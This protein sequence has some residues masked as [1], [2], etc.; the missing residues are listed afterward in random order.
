M[1]EATIGAHTTTD[2]VE[3]NFGCYDY[4][5]RRWVG[6]SPEN[7]SGIAQQMRMHDLERPSQVVSDCRKAKQAQPARSMGFFYELPDSMQRSLV[8]ACRRFRLK[9]RREARAD[10]KAQLAYKQ[11]KQEENI[12]LYAKSLR[13]FPAWQTNGFTEIGQ[14]DKLIKDKAV[15]DA[16]K[17]KQL[18]SQIEMR[19][20]ALGMSD[21]ATSFSCATDPHVGSIPHLR[22]V[23][24]EV[25]VEAKARRRNGAPPFQPDGSAPTEAQPPQLQVKTLEVL[26]T[27]TCDCKRLAAE[28]RLGA[29]TL[30]DAAMA[31]RQH[32]IEAGID[33]SV[34]E[35]T[36]FNAPELTNEKLQERRLEICWGTYYMPDGSRTGMWCPCKVLRVADGMTDK[37]GSTERW[38]RPSR[39]AQRS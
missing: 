27:P 8:E 15:S 33:D 18:I 20:V 30:R 32:R 2:R 6:I 1:H 39:A 25:L 26:G 14:A 3:S 11:R 13:L 31:E 9:S 22:G 10:R 35:I 21:S 12:D 19:V 17:K 5:L 28:A 16:V 36:P 34:E 37:R 23:L 24:K 29:E 7:A 38:T 4:V